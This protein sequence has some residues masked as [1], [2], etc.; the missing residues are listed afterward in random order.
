MLKYEFYRATQFYEKDENWSI[1]FEGFELEYNDERT[2]N[3]TFKDNTVLF[4][5]DDVPIEDDDVKIAILKGL[6][7]SEYEIEE[8]DETYDKYWWED[9]FYNISEDAHDIYVLAMDNNEKE[10]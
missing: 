5:E 2:V 7:N 8:D 4:T 10:R 3:I 6:K 9:F 1:D